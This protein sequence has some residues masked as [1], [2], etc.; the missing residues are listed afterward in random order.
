M[1][2]HCLKVI[3]KIKYLFSFGIHHLTLLANRNVAN[4]Q[5]VSENIKRVG[6]KKMKIASESKT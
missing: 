6:A 3:F 2:T 5:V 1:E 4:C